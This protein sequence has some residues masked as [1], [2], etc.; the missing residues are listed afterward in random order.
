MASPLYQI[1]KVCPVCE[2]KFNV[3]KVRGQT[4]AAT[5]DTDFCTHFKG[6]NPYYYAI[7]VCPNC[8]Y[9]A[10]ED[11]FLGVLDGPKQQ[12]KAFLAS[13]TV[14]ID[15]TGERTWEQ[16]VNA[17]K[18]ALY[19]ADMVGLSSSHLASLALRLA[20]LY[21]EKEKSE[22]EQ[23]A[24]A[25]AIEYYKQA[26]AKERFPIGNLTEVTVTFIIGE[27][28]RRVG[29]HEEALSYFSKVVSHP[30]AKNERRIFELA[31]NAWQEARAARKK[32]DESGGDGV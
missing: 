17:H 1:E 2:K 23:P 27:L 29:Q 5:V 7:W 19:Y 26:Y 22:E 28:L 16:A 32:D 12:L 25:R 3:T 6:I 31:R 24:L 15:Y 21:R 10:H 9:A 20:W 14:N 8:G 30:Q 18:L 4:V 11:R 13:R